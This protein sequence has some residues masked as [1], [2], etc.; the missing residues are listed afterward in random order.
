MSGP[1]SAGKSPMMMALEA[2]DHYWCSCGLSGKQPMCDGAHKGTSF[3][4]HKF[5][6][7]AGDKVAMCMC[8]RTKTAPFCDGAHA[9]L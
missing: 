1:R 4:P 3:T 2:G 6:V 8:K 7:A 9:T 5:T